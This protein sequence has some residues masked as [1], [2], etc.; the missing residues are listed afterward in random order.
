MGAWLLLAALTLGLWV[1]VAPP[2]QDAMPVWVVELDERRPVPIASTDLTLTVLKVWEAVPGCLGGPM[3]CPGWVRLQVA[4]SGETA[5]VHLA[6]WRTAAQPQPGLV[7]ARRF[8]YRL[9]LM[10]LH[11]TWVTLRVERD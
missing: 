6:L 9:T 8:G 2:A 3:G 4:R 7:Q 5:E 11:G 10:A 1:G